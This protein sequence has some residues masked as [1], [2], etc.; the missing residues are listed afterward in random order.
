MGNF[1]KKDL[2]QRA[3]LRAAYVMRS[4]WE[5]KG[6]SDTRLLDPPII[7][8][9]LVVVGESSAGKVHREH[10]VPRMKICVECHN[11][12]ARGGSVKDAA[13]FIQHHLKIVWISREEQQRLDSARELGWRQRMPPDWMPGGNVFAR[14]D[15]AGI[16]YRLY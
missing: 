16:T 14:L 10:V 7:P 12:F 5:E 1:T 8:D 11:I 13:E 3:C 2:L 6:S 15:S 9:E 4:M